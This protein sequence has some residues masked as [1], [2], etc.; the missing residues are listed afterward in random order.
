[1]N[2]KSFYR[3]TQKGWNWLWLEI[4]STTYFKNPIISKNLKMEAAQLAEQPS[5][6]EEAYDLINRG[7]S[8]ITRELAVI[9]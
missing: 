9:Q 6:I 4:T 2:D 3:V 5:K 8:L 7:L 1:M